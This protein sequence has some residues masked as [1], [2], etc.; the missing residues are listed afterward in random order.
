MMATSMKK[1][2]ILELVNGLP[3][4]V[5]VTKLI[6]TLYVRR[7]IDRGLADADAGREVSL[8]EI[9]QMIDEWPE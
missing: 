2:E 4:E 8:E 5:D 9:D 3:D 6:Y 7:E 1:S